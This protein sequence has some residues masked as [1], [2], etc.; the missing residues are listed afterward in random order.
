MG[1]YNQWGSPGINTGTNSFCYIYIND[2]LY[3]LHQD[4]KP[5]IFAVDTSVLL[6]LKTERVKIQLHK[7]PRLHDRMVHSKWVGI[8]HGENQYNEILCKHHQTEIFH[9]EHLNKLTTEKNSINF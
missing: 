1:K 9:I 5:V 4:A 8:K 2:L 7:C 3:G 6:T